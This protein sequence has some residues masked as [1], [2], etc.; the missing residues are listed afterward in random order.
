MWLWLRII[1][2]EGELWMHG[3]PNPMY[4]IFRLWGCMAFMLEQIHYYL[5]NWWRWWRIW[6]TGRGLR[7][8]SSLAG[9]GL[10]DL[11]MYKHVA[12]LV[13]DLV[14]IKKLFVNLSDQPLSPLWLSYIHNSMSYSLFDSTSKFCV[15]TL[16]FYF[17]CYCYIVLLSQACHG[18]VACRVTV[19]GVDEL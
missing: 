14:N 5:A 18:R 11:Y 10:K 12:I 6:C 17:S 13:L 19:V 8:S 2:H 15:G 4:N 3:S 1:M 16:G 9:V 7:K